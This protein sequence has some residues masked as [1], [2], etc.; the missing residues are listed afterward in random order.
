M[1]QPGVRYVISSTILRYSYSSQPM[2]SCTVLDPL[3]AEALRQ[4]GHLSRCSGE[5]VLGQ[6]SSY[7]FRFYLFLLCCVILIL[8]Y[9]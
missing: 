6:S 4:P 5:D 3:G 2:D 9:I 8:S 1:R 7:I